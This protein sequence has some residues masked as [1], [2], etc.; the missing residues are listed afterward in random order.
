MVSDLGAQEFVD[1]GHGA[2]VLGGDP[3]LCAP[4][5]LLIEIADRLLL[6]DQDGHA[7]QDP[8][9]DGEGGGEI[10]AGERS[11]DLGQVGPDGLP[12]LRVGRRICIIRLD[13]DDASVGL[14]PEVVGGAGE[15]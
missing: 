4:F 1:G 14:D 15:G 9:M 5:G 8:L 7:G 13:L 6:L 12:A 10:A 11:G 2:G 3:H